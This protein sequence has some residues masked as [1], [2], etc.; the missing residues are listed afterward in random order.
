MSG[1]LTPHLFSY[2]R[3]RVIEVGREADGMWSCTKTISTL[4]C[5]TH[6]GA[7]MLRGVNNRQNNIKISVRTRDRW[8]GFDRHE[9][10]VVRQIQTL[11]PCSRA[12]FYGFADIKNAILDQRKEHCKRD[13]YHHR[14]L[15]WSDESELVKNH[16]L[17][18]CSPFHLVL[19]PDCGLRLLN[20]IEIE[21]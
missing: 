21:L 2:E 1:V 8:A 13:S 14:Q 5:S 17:R 12:L 11:L 7:L 6:V 15:C 16:P 19:F 4:R 9:I 3:E 18:E 10:M 20:W